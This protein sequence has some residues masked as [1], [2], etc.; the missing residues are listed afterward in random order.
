MTFSFQVDSLNNETWESS[1]GR[2]RI[3]HHPMSQDLWWLE[4]ITMQTCHDYHDLDAAKY[5]AAELDAE[6]QERI[7]SFTQGII[8]LD[9]PAIVEERNASE[10]QGI[11]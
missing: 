8:D 3:T 9:I 5:K 11:R 2:F 7:A 6:D 10:P 1:C 4:D